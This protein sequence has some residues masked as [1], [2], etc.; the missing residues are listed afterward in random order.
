MHH[1]L[2]LYSRYREGV[3]KFYIFWAKWTRIRL[4]GRLV[5]WVANTYGRNLEG[6][7]LLTIDEAEDIVDSAEGV[8]LGPCTCRSVF[9]NCDR[10]V[11]VE[12]MLGPIGHILMEHMADDFREVTGQEAKN[13]LRDCHRQGLIHSIIKCQ[14]DFYAICN[15]CSCCCVPLRLSKEYGIGAAL[16]RSGDIVRQFKS[17]QLAHQD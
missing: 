15:C 6:A 10:S 11:G 2:R 14:Q 3:L 9:K 5:R 4:V 7:Y 12:I 13:V 17:R 1:S 16:T 8:A